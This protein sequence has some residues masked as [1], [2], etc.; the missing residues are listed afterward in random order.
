MNN[1]LSRTI[2]GVFLILLGIWFFLFL[3]FVG[4]LRLDFIVIITGLFFIILGIFI[5]LNSK[6]DK[7]EGI[8]KVKGGKRK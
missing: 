7:I 8:K 2:I 6:E 1:L 3:G 4:G 5:L